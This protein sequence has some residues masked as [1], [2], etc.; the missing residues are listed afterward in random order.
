[1]EASDGIVYT[2]YRDGQDYVLKVLSFPLDDTTAIER[3]NHQLKFAHFLS[4]NGVNI[5]YPIVSKSD[6]LFEKCSNDKNTFLAYEMQKLKGDEPDPRVWDEEFFKEWGRLTGYSHAVTK[7][8]PIWK[9]AKVSS[10]K[11][12]LTWTEEW[13]NL[14]SRCK[15]SEIQQLWKEI[16]LSLDKLPI[17]RDCFGMIHNDNHTGNLIVHNKNITKI[18]I[19]GINCFWFASEFVVAMQEIMYEQTGGIANKLTKPD[20]IRRFFDLFLMGYEKENHISPEMLKHV[21]LF[22]QYRR[23]FLYILF[24]NYYKEHPEEN[25]K[26]LE[27][28]RN[29]DQ[30]I[31]F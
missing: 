5:A 3:L 17:N 14:S 15:D 11:S 21:N 20:K 9:E 18:D 8:Y 30:V 31:K 12:V 27:V 2:H 29:N 23:V 7:L 1:M 22:I 25:M 28:I 19:E 26:V 16:R 4:E 13:E 6:S 24:R 10:G